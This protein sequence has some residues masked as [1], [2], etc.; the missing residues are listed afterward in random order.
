MIGF[1]AHALVGT[2]FGGGGCCADT[3]AVPAIAIDA[4]MRNMLMSFE[5]SSVNVIRG[6]CKKSVDQR[7]NIDVF[8]RKNAGTDLGVLSDQELMEVSDE[9]R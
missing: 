2:G 5:T 4:M 8:S 1:G 7:A 6:P 3:T 9:D